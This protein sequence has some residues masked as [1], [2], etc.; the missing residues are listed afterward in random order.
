MHRLESLL[1]IVMLLPAALPLT[2][3]ETFRE[4]DS[5][6]YALYKAAAWDSLADFGTN[7]YAEGYDYYYLNLRTAIAFYELGNYAAALRFF[8]RAYRNNSSDPVLK[9]YL[10]WSNYH[11]LHELE[12]SRWYRLLDDSV[13]QGIPFRPKRRIDGLYAEGGVRIPLQSA[14]A[15]PVSYAHL[16]LQAYPIERLSLSQALSYTAQ[17]LNWGRFR[18]Y[19]YYLRPE[20]RISR[21]TGIYLAGHWAHYHSRL[22]YESLSIRTGTF[23]DNSQMGGHRV[24]TVLAS[25]YR[26]SGSYLEFDYLVQA[27]FGKTGKRYSVTPY[28]SYWLLKQNPDYTE[29]FNDT[30]RIVEYRGPVVVGEFM[31]SSDSTSTPGSGYAAQWVLGMSAYY[32]LGKLTLGGD[33]KY[34]GNSDARYWFFSPFLAWRVGEKWNITAY[35]FSKKNY[36]ISLFSGYQLF[37]TFDEMQRVSLSTRYALTEKTELYLTLQHDRIADNLTGDP[38]EMN[39]LYLGINFKF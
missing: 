22:D 12:A 20:W 2:A 35:Y 16:A 13:R 31:D 17:A 38:Y 8:E 15:G 7:A 28:V 34:T 1:F 37:N 29:T 3:Q 10:F 19:Q 26:I 33:L 30:L 24:D 9:E 21:S 11:L 23:S 39:D 18:Q 5:S 6:S 27:G 14:T 25:A 36:P 4:V 32:R